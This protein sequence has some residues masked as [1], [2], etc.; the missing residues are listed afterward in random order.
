M[1]ISLNN[2]NKTIYDLILDYFKQKSKKEV[3]KEDNREN[4]KD[5]N[6]KNEKYIKNKNE[7]NLNNTSFDL[8]MEYKNNNL[9]S[10]IGKLIIS[11]NI[12]YL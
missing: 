6:I 10:K 5:N 1:T 4:K 11:F 2:L 8:P 12:F 9:N 7:T 3:N